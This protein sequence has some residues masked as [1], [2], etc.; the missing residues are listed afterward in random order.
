M[1]KLISLV[2]LLPMIGCE[3]PCERLKEIHACR[4]DKDCFLSSDD[5]A[6]WKKLRKSEECAAEAIMLELGV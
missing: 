2:L 5:L 6:E 4:Q 1:K 3:P